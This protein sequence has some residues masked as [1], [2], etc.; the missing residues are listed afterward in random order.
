MSLNAELEEW[1]SLRREVDFSGL[2]VGNG[3]SCAVWEGFSYPSLFNIARNDNATHRLETQDVALFEALAT[4]NFEQ[5]LSALVISRRVSQVFGLP[6][7]Q[8]DQCYESVQSALIEAVQTKHVAKRDVSDDAF[9]SI[10]DELARYRCVYSTNYDLLTYWAI[11]H[12]ETGSFKDLFWGE[13]FDLA[14]TDVWGRYTIVLY[15]HGGLHL[16]RAEDG[17]TLKRRSQAGANLL[18]LFGTPIE[19]AEDATPL[20]VSEGTSAD[21][22]KSIYRSDYLAFA[23][24]SLAHH[25]GPLCIFGNGLGEE[26][27]HIVAAI[28]KA[29][30]TEIAISIRPRDRAQIIADKA[31]FYEQL[32][33]ANLRFFD[34]T[35][36]P[37]GAAAL[38]VDDGAVDF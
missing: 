15:L 18:E 6:H 9:A 33:K 2:L 34:S 11:M 5:V 35:S 26:D 29:E 12:G 22:L 7:T 27:R 19:G 4:T 23:Y 25:D 36:H 1:R 13:R 10:R 16:Y 30:T 21:K 38:Q 32:P 31:H 17:E 28:E 8:H 3:A 24:T 37:L 14:N 20:F